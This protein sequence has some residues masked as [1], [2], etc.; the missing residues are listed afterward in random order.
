[1]S[2]S[3]TEP[4]DARAEHSSERNLRL[5]TNSLIVANVVTGA[6][7]LVFWVAAARLFPAREVGIAAAQINSAVMLSFLSILSLD[8][9]YE[10]FLPVS[11]TH[12]RSLLKHGF[13]LVAVVAALAGTALVVFGP[14]ESMFDSGWEMVSYPV[15]VMVLAVFTLQDKATAG[16]GVARWA[17]AKNAIHSMG[18][19]IAVLALAWTGA[20]VS[21]VLAWGVTAAVIALYLLFAL[22]RRSRSN[23]RFLGIPN[24]PP[25]QQLWSYFGSSF[26]LTACWAV[27]NLAVPLIVLTQVG[28]EANAY[29]AVS[30]AIIIALYVTLD[31]IVSPYVAEAAANPDKVISLTWRM[32]RTLAVVTCMGS[33]GLAVVAPAMLSVVGAEYR[34]QGQGLLYLA[35]IFV[36]LAAVT[37]VYEG[38]ARL[39]RRLRLLLGVR[40]V[41]TVVIVCGSLILTRTA[42]VSGV[43]WAC[44]AAESV[45]AAVLIGPV[46]VWIRRARSGEEV[47]HQ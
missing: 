5:N 3:A 20:A 42:G 7:G 44:L 30:W 27:G 22:D 4:R 1:M 32:L 41:A 35:A 36:P 25:R 47:V 18:K 15:L 34:T 17:A 26:G 16:L 38:F 19:L 23:P 29:F 33:I 11:G 31:L 46:I 21:I 6:L 14:R 10:R 12:A 43:G 8:T 45:A 13:L 9:I 40:C 28:A 2:V 39:Q 24:L 37:A